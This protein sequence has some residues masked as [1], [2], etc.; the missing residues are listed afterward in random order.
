ML[1]RVDVHNAAAPAG[2]I[3]TLALDSDGD[4]ANGVIYDSHDAGQDV[5]VVCPWGPSSFEW[6][7][8]VPTDAPLGQYAMNVSFHD[9]LYVLGFE[10][11]GWQSALAVVARKV[12]SPAPA[13]LRYTTV[14][15]ALKS[16]V[17]DG[18]A[19]RDAALSE[20]VGSRESAQ[21]WQGLRAALSQI[22]EAAQEAYDGGVLRRRLAALRDALFG[23]AAHC[24]W[25]RA[26]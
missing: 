25:E 2:V 14:R 7:W 8:T 11:P 4:P 3:A 1:I 20:L 23:D 13:I 24:V 26:G 18:A 9:P 22:E 10:D 12:V 6:T 17:S 5:Q 16:A 19:A 15:T 21:V